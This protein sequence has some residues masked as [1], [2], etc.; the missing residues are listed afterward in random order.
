VAAGR[1]F[2]LFGLLR[3]HGLDDA[4]VLALGLLRAPLDGEGRRSEERDR[5][6]QG[7]Q[8]LHQKT[9]VRSR[10]DGLVEGEV[11]LRARR[12][13]RRQVALGLDEVAQRS[14]VARACVAGRERGGSAFKRLAH[15]VEFRDGVGLERRDHQAGAGNQGDEPLPFEPRQGRAHRRAADSEPLGE[16]DLAHAPPRGE[17]PPRISARSVA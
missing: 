4:G 9:V 2:G 8:A 10:V 3:R 6:V 12:G 13:V 5:V 17:A 11:V 16:L 14:H 15:L 1:G 7:V